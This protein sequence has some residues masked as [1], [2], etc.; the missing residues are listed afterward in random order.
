M[1]YQSACGPFTW[2]RKNS[3]ER[4]DKCI[5]ELGLVKLVVLFTLFI[6]VLVC[7]F[8]HV[9][10]CECVWVTQRGR[11]TETLP[12]KPRI[13]SHRELAAHTSL[14]LMPADM[15]SQMERLPGI[16]IICTAWP[17]CFCCVSVMRAAL[18]TRPATRPADRPLMHGV[19]QAQCLPLQPLI[20]SPRQTLSV[21][22]SSPGY[23]QV[24]VKDSSARRDYCHVM[25]L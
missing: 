15:F 4:W 6:H 14:V 18:C 10:V 3:E 11:E 7:R 21:K 25:H 12:L 24:K 19:Q 9:Y 23:F 1:W 16:M 13:V 20:V 5:E 17:T 8:V 22:L 2:S